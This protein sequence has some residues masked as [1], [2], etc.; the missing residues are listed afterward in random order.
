MLYSLDDIMIEPAPVTDIRHRNEVQTT[1]DDGYLPIFTSPMPCVVSTE[2]SQY[3]R[4][5]EGHINPI[6]P[7]TELIETRLDFDQYGD[8]F[9]AFSL[10]EFEKYFV[11]DDINASDYAEPIKVLI[12][13]ACGNMKHLHDVIKAAK[14][15]H[16]DNLIIM[17]G[18][19]A[20]PR[21]FEEL[22]ASGCDY[23]RC[24]VG[25]GS[26]CNTAT[27]TGVYYPMA[28]LLESCYRLKKSFY[29]KVKIIAD[30]GITNF[31]NAYKALALGA[32]Y[33][34]MGSRL[35]QCSD[36]AG[37][38][39]ING[40]TGDKCKVYYGM[41]S[42]V[43]SQMLG[44]DIVAPEG[45]IKK[46]PILGPISEFS[47]LF[48]KYLASTMSYCNCRNLEEFIGNQKLVIISPSAAKQFNQ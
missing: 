4:Y 18:N 19:V 40:E 46:Y 7:R 11:E 42:K 21:G 2:A 27:Y 24:S 45:M 10:N 44:K 8:M 28:S 16:G 1:Y 35:C 3:K 17:S 13:I 38:I 25:T 15:K 20:S 31:R 48:S 22:A 6:L 41:A 23:I 26:G 12:D 9:I 14:A 39:D 5:I 37:S 34:M 33:V 29:K 43:G 30:G 36:S 47:T 32:D